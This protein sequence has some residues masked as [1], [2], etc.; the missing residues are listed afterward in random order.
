MPGCL[1]E[2]GHYYFLGNVYKKLI[3]VGVMAC[4]KNIDHSLHVIDFTVLKIIS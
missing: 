2:M 1:S 4:L 3:K